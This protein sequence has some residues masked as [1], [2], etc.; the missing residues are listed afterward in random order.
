[1]KST[2]PQYRILPRFKVGEIVSFSLYIKEDSEKR[3]H[4]EIVSIYRIDNVYYY[5][6]KGYSYLFA[7]NLLAPII[8]I[9]ER[10]HLCAEDLDNLSSFFTLRNNTVTQDQNIP[11]QTK[12]KY[13]PG[14]EI[15]V[16]MQDGTFSRVTTVEKYAKL[17]IR[18]HVHVYI[19]RVSAFVEWIPEELLCVPTTDDSAIRKLQKIV[20]NFFSYSKS[21]IYEEIKSIC[22]NLAEQED[23]LLRINQKL[24]DE[25]NALKLAIKKEKASSETI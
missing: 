14:Q 24:I 9:V 1:M 6:I 11:K 20:D 16:N 18:P 8:S 7:E 15:Q 10:L 21:D 22:K 2:D 3:G 17:M 4:G 25:I 13:E 19:Y 12:P 5:M 23:Y